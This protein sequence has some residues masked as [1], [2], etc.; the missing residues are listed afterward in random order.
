[1]NQVVYLPRL[2]SAAIIKKDGKILLGRRNKEPENGK[3]VL[4]GGKVEE[5]ETIKDAA[6][7]ELLEE[8]GIEVDVGEPIGVYEIISPPKE[9]RI[10]VYSWARVKS[11]NLKPSSDTSELRFFSKEDISHIKLTDLVKRVLQDIAFL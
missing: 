6:K 2:G 7:R 9:H 4:P 11:G 1:M 5:F 10:I 3:W 8:A